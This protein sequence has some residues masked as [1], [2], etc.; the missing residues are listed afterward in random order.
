[1]SS[2]NLDP[3]EDF[4]EAFHLSALVERWLASVRVEPETRVTYRNKIHWFVA[5]WQREGAAAGWRLTRKV[6]EDFEFYLRSAVSDFT[7]RR[8]TFNSRTAIVAA[9][10]RMFKWSA[11][12]DRTVRNFGEWLPW[13]SGETSL[14]RSATVEQLT[15]LMLA[16]AQ[17]PH[18]VRDQAIV[19]FFIGTGCRACEV[20]RLRRSD[21]IFASDGSG[22]AF[23]TGKRTKAN[24]T[25]ERSV[26]FDAVTGGWMKRHMATIS[27]GTDI[28][29]VSARS[30]K[31]LIRTGVIGVVTRAIVRADLPSSVRGCHDLRRAFATILVQLHPESAAW[32]DMIRRQLG[33]RHYSQTA[34]YTLIEVDDIRKRIVTPLLL[35]QE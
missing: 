19:A 12:T 25:G 23:V 29:W 32:A 10:R 13:P 27:L 18:P 1:M 3:V 8:L 30:G 16:A 28:L 17:S 24:P 22:T 7:R 26:A 34:A 20:A 15:A 9:V 5:W 6:L 2:I 21:L 14:R 11:R 4:L 31:P 35:N 33:H